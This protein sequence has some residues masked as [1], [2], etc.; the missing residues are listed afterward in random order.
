MKANLFAAELIS[1]VANGSAQ[2]LTAAIIC[3]LGAGYDNAAD[4]GEQLN[5]TTQ[6]AAAQLL[7]MSKAGLVAPLKYRGHFELAQGGRDILRELLDFLHR[8]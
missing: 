3:Q 1:A 4:I 8:A 2:P 6:K 7:A 5:I